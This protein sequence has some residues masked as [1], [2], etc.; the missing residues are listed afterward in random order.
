MNPSLVVRVKFPL[1]F[2]CIPEIWRQVGAF[3]V[4]RC[5]LILFRIAM[6]SRF[7]F[8][9]S[10]LRWMMIVRSIFFAGPVVFV[11]LPL[12]TTSFHG[13]AL[14]IFWGIIVVVVWGC[15][16]C[17]CSLGLV[18]VS[19]TGWVVWG[20][21]L[22]VWGIVMEGLILVFLRSYCIRPSNL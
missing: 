19:G 16:V 11:F 18:M 17:C 15:A 14:V 22:D 4:I 2:Q 9:S 13:V 5:M 6:V 3:A 7:S 10:D 21:F 8:L 1:R 12:L 20:V